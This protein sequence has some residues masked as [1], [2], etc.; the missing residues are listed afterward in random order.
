[1]PPLVPMCMHRCLVFQ[2]QWNRAGI[3]LVQVR[4][5]KAEKQCMKTN[6]IPS[7]F[8]SACIDSLCNECNER[9]WYEYLVFER[10]VAN[11]SHPE[12][13]SPASVVIG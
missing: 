12:N 4:N 7:S 10:S 1:M 11:R 5:V 9:L 2:S 13:A 3:T 8:K 6:I